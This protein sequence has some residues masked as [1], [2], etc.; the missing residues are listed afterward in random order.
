MRRIFFL[1]ALIGTSAFAEPLGTLTVVVQGLRSQQGEVA[2]ALYADEG[3][4]REREGEFRAGRIPADSS[5]I[6]WEL[7]ELDYAE[8]AVLA[9]HD[10]NGNGELD[11]DDRGRPTEPVAFSGEP[12]R[13]GKPPRF[14]Q[15]AFEFGER[16]VTLELELRHRDRADQGE[17]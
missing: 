17:D 14:R 6:R 7:P 10:V 2:L 8:Y 9:F 1:L 5:E 16:S 12:R 13:R 4:Y 3:S 11:L 15:A